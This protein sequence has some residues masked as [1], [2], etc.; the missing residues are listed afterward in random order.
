MTEV[1]KVI[2]KMAGKASLWE[3]PIYKD[4]FIEETPEK[5]TGTQI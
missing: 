5:I 3:I 1:T 2:K 4:I